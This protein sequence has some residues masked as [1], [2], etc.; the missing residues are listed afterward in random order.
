MRA[1]DFLVVAGIVLLI[2]FSAAW[3]TSRVIV[4]R[5]SDPRLVSA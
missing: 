2:G 1:V 5:Q 4:K 3:Y